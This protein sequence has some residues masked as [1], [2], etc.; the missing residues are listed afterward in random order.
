VCSLTDST[1]PDL[2]ID[3]PFKAAGAATQNA[4]S[5]VPLQPGTQQE[6]A[7]VTVVYALAR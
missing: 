4:P 3:E 7:Q 1:T 5:A 6:S 2:G